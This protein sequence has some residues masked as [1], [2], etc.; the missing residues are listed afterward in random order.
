[1]S[2]AGEVGLAAEGQPAGAAAGGIGQAA[3]RPCRRRP[4]AVFE[5][6]HGIAAEGGAVPQSVRCAAAQSALGGQTIAERDSREAGR[7]SHA[8]RI[9]MGGTASAVRPLGWRNR[10]PILAAHQNHPAVGDAVT[11]WPVGASPRLPLGRCGRGSRPFDRPRSD[12]SLRCASPAPRRGP[13]GLAPLGA[14]FMV[15]SSE[16]DRG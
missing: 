13:E 11:M 2:H 5:L 1:M 16:T 12:P 4:L 14:R 7:I 9:V 15:R 3:D 8:G 6:P 10:R